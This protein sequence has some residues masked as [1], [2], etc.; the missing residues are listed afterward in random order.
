MEEI[1]SQRMEVDKFH[2]AIARL[3]EKQ[4]HRLVLYYF[5]EF[6]YEPIAEMEGCTKRAVKF[7][8]TII[9]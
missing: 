6:T 2:R 3:P 4:R 5:G 1:V 8:V 9:I 7:S